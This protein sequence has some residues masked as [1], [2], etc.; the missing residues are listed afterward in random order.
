MADYIPH[1]DAAFNPR[2]DNFIT[3]AG[4]NPDRLAVQAYREGIHGR[5]PR[6]L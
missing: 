5:V 1:G 3:Y 2:A 6:I 4:N